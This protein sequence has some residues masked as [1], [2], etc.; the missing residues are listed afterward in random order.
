MM[1]KPWWKD[2]L[3]FKC[4]QC[5]HCCRIE[6]YVW[7]NQ[8][9]IDTL[10][11]NLEMTPEEFE[12]KYVRRV[13]RRRSLVEK[14]NHECIFWEEGCSVYEARPTQCK[15]FPFWK[16]NLESMEDWLE[17]VE[18]CPGSGTGVVYTAEEIEQLQQGKGETNK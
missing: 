4:T 8:K 6:G 18:E 15:T 11:R 14:P 9:E 2:G 10:A 12:W 16:H 1:A 3:P 17:V 5:G 7:V 13:G